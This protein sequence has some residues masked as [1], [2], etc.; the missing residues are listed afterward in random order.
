MFR[1]KGMFNG[2]FSLYLNG[3]FFEPASISEDFWTEGPR[4][5]T[6]LL[7][8]DR[9]WYDSHFLDMPKKLPPTLR[10]SS[11]EEIHQLR[12]R[13]QGDI[14]LIDFCRRYPRRRGSED[15]EILTETSYAKYGSIR[16]GTRL[17]HDQSILRNGLDVTL[18][19][20]AGLSARNM[21]HFCVAINPKGRFVRQKHDSLLRGNQPKALEA[22]RALLLPGLEGCHS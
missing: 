12:N 8:E 22:L 1:P 9:K 13:L 19:T 7:T 21:I 14:V 17:Y 6:T 3:R 10:H 2:N 20:R 16:H 5:L 11:D 15:I 4:P 18:G